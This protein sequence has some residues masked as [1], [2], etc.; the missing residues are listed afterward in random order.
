MGSALEV[1][2]GSLA[3]LETMV[4]V[5]AG[6]WAA[7]RAAGSAGLE[8]DGARAA[9]KSAG[10]DFIQ[11]YRREQG[12]WRRAEQVVAEGL[13]MAERPELGDQLEAA[14]G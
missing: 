14:L 6:E 5:Q 3:R 13:I 2:K 11:T 7:R 1:T 9:L 12:R 4:V 10:I 8:S